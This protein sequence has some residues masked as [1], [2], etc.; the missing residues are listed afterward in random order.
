MPERERMKCP[1]GLVPFRLDLKK[2]FE[3]LPMFVPQDMLAE[4]RRQAPKLWIEPIGDLPLNG[5][6]IT[7]AAWQGVL[8]DSSKSA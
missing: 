8:Q 3:P 2:P 4:A 6:A 1:T 7:H 5:R